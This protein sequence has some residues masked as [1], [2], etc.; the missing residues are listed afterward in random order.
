VSAA[1]GYRDGGFGIAG[2]DG[3][4]S[5]ELCELIV[6]DIIPRGLDIVDAGETD[7]S[8]SLIFLSSM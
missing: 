2:T 1:I 5:E 4:S 3:S 7:V 6:G 8:G